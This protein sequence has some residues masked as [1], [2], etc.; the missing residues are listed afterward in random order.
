MMNVQRTVNQTDQVL[1]KYPT[2]GQKQSLEFLQHCTIVTS[3]SI[4]RPA[5]KHFDDC[6]VKNFEKFFD[7]F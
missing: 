5:G 4:S 6:L 7:K 2:S 1:A 3:T